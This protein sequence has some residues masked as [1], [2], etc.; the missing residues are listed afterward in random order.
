MA[1]DFDK[2]IIKVIFDGLMTPHNSA[3]NISL[4]YGKRRDIRFTQL[5]VIHFGIWWILRA[6][7]SVSTD[8]PLKWKNSSIFTRL[9]VLLGNK[10][11]QFTFAK[12]E[13]NISF[14]DGSWSILLDNT[15]NFMNCCI[16]CCYSSQK[17]WNDVEKSG[18]TFCTWNAWRD[19]DHSQSRREDE[20]TE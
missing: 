10:E 14:S 5:K 17:N 13:R 9:D 16:H 3:W 8:C 12:F 19:T 7:P 20:G 2:D 6:T 11:W 4:S 1:D 18:N 15:I